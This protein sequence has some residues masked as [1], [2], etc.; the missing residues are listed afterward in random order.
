MAGYY[1]ITFSFFVA[2]LFAI[3]SAIIPVRLVDALQVLN[4][5]V[6]LQ[7]SPLVGGPAWLP[8]HCK[9]V[10]DGSHVFDFIPLNADST[11]TIQ[12]LISLQAVPA[13]VRTTQKNRKRET[14]DNN[15]NDDDGDDELTNLY[16]ERAVQFCQE[17][18]ED[19][20]LINNNCWSFAIDLL[21]YISHAES[22]RG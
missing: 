20:H 19:L 7:P 10:V 15:N 18:D 6:K 5:R 8:V 1:S 22:K 11:K 4:N 13:T 21:R 16:V 9:V 2:F 3:S 12:K 17:Y 14:D